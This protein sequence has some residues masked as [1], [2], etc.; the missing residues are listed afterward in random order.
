MWDVFGTG[1]GRAG[2]M[3]YVILWLRV[4]FGAHCLLSGVNYFLP[5]VPPP[6]INLSPAGQ[7]VKEMDVVGLYALIKVVEI[8]AGVLLIL[9]RFVPLAL[10][11]EMPTTLSIFYLNTFVDGQ[12]RQLYTGPREL[13]YNVLLIFA[14][15]AYF[16]AML[17]PNAQLSPLWKGSLSD[18]GTN[19]VT[20]ETEG[21]FLS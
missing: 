14:Y 10:V 15:W 18:K 3:P 4:A 16:R 2:W 11:I 19:P 8:V 17:V 20:G 5:L 21:K 1:Q 13:L 12:P 6:P 9:N 7:F